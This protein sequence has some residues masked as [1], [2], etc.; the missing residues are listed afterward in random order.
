M[1]RLAYLGDFPF[2]HVTSWRKG[3]HLGAIRCLYD[4]WTNCAV[5]FVPVIAEFLPPS[6]RSTWPDWTYQAGWYVLGLDDLAL[7]QVAVRL[8]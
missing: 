1:D 5:T 2:L 7:R 8:P 6:P 3:V 4:T